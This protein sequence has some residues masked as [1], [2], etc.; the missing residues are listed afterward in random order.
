MRGTTPR[1]LE[2][3]EVCAVCPHWET[4]TDRRG[5][6]DAQTIEAL[7]EALEDEYRARAVYQKVIE[8][9]GPVRPFVNI[10]EAAERHAQALLRIFDRLGVHRPQ[11][12]WPNRV[13]AP[14]SLVEACEA[15]VRAEIDSKAM[16]RRLLPQVKDPAARRVM[17]RLQEASQQRHLP[18][19]RRCLARMAASTP[20]AGRP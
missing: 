17:R 10:V 19:F 1:L 12:R 18:A 3:T 14:R 8:A 2:T 9:F 4:C 13:S 16:Y 6:P 15:A 11:N 20:A 7:R 5:T